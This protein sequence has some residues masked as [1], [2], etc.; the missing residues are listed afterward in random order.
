MSIIH[1]KNK[2]VKYAGSLIGLGVVF[3]VAWSIDH[4]FAPPKPVMRY[5]IVADDW[6]ITSE[7][8]QVNF[9]GHKVRNCPLIN[10]S[11]KGKALINDKMVDVEFSWYEDRNPD[12][13]YP[14]GYI[15]PTRGRWTHPHM[16]RATRTG[17]VIVHKCPEGD[18]PSYYWYDV[19]V[20]P[21]DDI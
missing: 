10:D 13:T 15:H 19:P 12:T 21:E 6:E 11:E 16:N 1:P 7:Y 14:V 3:F 18:V 17:L 9:Q 5:L 2:A 4:Y 20:N 8:A